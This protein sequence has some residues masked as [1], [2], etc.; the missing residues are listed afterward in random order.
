MRG[1]DDKGLVEP[2]EANGI[3][4]YGVGRADDRL[5]GYRVTDRL[6]ST[7]LVVSVGGRGGDDGG[8]LHGGGGERL[9]ALEAEQRGLRG[10]GAGVD[11][12]RGVLLRHLGAQG[13]TLLTL[14]QHLSSSSNNRQQSQDG[15]DE[16]ALSLSFLIPPCHT[17]Q[18]W[19]DTES[20]PSPPHSAV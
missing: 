4:F 8:A 3:V 17:P 16:T 20:P 13:L 14:Q 1:Q 2:R 9:L 5:V 18:D 12:E 15:S 6:V 10:D 19:H 7:D 11:G